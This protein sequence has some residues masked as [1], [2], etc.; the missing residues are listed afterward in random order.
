MKLNRKST[1]LAVL[2]LLLISTKLALAQTPLVSVPSGFFG[3]TL[4]DSSHWPTIPFGALGKAPGVSWPF[5]EPTKGKF[6]WTRLDGWVNDANAHGL[7]F[8]WDSEYVPPWAAANPSSCR[9]G[10]FNTTVCTSTVA[11]IHIQDWKNFMTALVTRYRGR[12][13]VYELWNEPSSTTVYTGTVAD[14]VILT[15]AEHDVIRSIDPSAKIVGPAMQSYRTDYLD[16]YFAAGGTKDIDA[17]TYHA[18]PNPKLDVAEFLMGSVVSGVKTVMAKY[19]LSG[20]P[21]WDTENSWGETKAG[22]ITDPDLRA[23]FVARDLLLSW[24][25]GTSRTYWCCWDNDE[26]GTVWSP[27]TGISEA[28]VAWEHVHKWMY[29]A[30]M[31]ACSLNGSTDFYHAVYT[32]DLKRSG[33]RWVGRAVWWTDGTKAY[34]APSQYTQYEILENSSIIR[35]PS[36]H[37]VTI[38]REPI[39]LENEDIP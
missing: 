4:M 11:N 9:A 34:T 5:V 6:N 13:Q 26:D 23:A 19:G 39:L 38:G 24:N 16:S 7:S 3:M 2:A 22:A 10:Y 12:I 31:S 28:G 14:F 30:T 1:S 27:S 29:G 21:L 15:R 36:N 32:C 33:T 35:I 37:Q 20:K 17:V 25:S 18:A 8:V